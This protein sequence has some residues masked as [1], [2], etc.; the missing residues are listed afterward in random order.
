MATRNDTTRK[1]PPPPN[2]AHVVG[3]ILAMGVIRLIEAQRTAARDAAGAP[4]N[5]A[6]PAGPHL[7]PDELDALELPKRMR[8]ADLF[9][10]R[11]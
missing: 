4:D 5:A 9:A 2:P 10:P 11:R 8:H 3:A 1:P 6:T 7:T